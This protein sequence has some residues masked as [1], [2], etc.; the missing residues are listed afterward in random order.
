M[1]LTAIVPRRETEFMHGLIIHADLHQPNQHCPDATLEI[2]DGRVAAIHEAG[3]ATPSLRVFF[4]AQHQLTFPGFVD[5]HTHGASGRDVCDGSPGALEAIGRAKIR[6]GVTTFLPT[7]LTIP[8]DELQKVAGLAAP[9]M[10]NPTFA[11]APALHIEGPFINRNCAGAQNPAHVRPPDSEEVREL[12]KITPVGLVSMA[13]ET[14]GGIAFIEEMT[15]LG[16]VTSLAHSAA[17]YAD[18]QAARQAGAKHLTHFCN[19]MTGLHHRE[20]GLV[21][22]A[23]LDDDVLIEAIC[24]KIHLCPEMISLTFKHLSINQMM[25][26]TD[27]MAASWMNEGSYDLAGLEVHVK[28]G[29][30]RLT[31]GALAG[32]TL[33]Y[34]HA[35]RNVHRI[36]NIP[37]LDL[38]K[39]CG[40]NQARSLGLEGGSLTQGSPADIVIVNDECEPVAVFV[41]GVDKLPEA[42]TP[43]ME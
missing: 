6:E 16:I 31:S 2:Q 12:H 18:F 4:D 13:P 25:L 38:T 32:S 29:A 22:A 41:D 10:A 20:I 33:R 26:V 43:P 27:S 11:K 36:T 15:A 17:T 42:S 40:Y 14:N 35:A 3:A 24:D 39:A 28:D 21:G 9:Y 19:Q 30:A 37:W 23:L 5:I 7:T 34:N 8:R 1:A